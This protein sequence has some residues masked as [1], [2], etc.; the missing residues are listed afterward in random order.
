MT[1]HD[2]ALLG[3]LLICIVAMVIGFSASS[4]G[5]KI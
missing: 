4:F 3:L 2:F 5:K 1:G